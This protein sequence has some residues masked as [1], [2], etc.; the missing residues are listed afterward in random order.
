V[1]P[2][3]WN[4]QDSEGAHY[5]MNRHLHNAVL[6]FPQAPAGTKVASRRYHSAGDTYEQWFTSGG[7]FSAT[8]DN[9]RFESLAKVSAITIDVD[10]YE[11]DAPDAIIRWGAT[12]DERKS[13]MR[14][15][16]EEEVVQWMVDEDFVSCAIT[17]AASVGLPAAPNRILYTGQGLC[18]VYWLAAD[19]GGLNDV[20]T[21]KRMKE[22]IKRFVATDADKLWWWDK[23]AKDVGTRLIPIPGTRH[24]VTGKQV[25]LVR[26]H[27]NVTPLT[28][29]FEKLDAAYPEVKKSAKPRSAA[30]KAPG[31]P[32]ARGTGTWTIITFDPSKHTALEVGES[33][34]E[35]PLCQGSGYKRMSAEHYSCFSCETQFRVRPSFNFNI[36]FSEKEERPEGYLELTPEGH[37]LWPLSTPVRLLN[38]A[39]TGAGKTELMRRE[40]KAWAPHDDWNARV[41]AVAP[42]IALAG[43]LS[44]RLDMPHAD[45]QSALTLSQDSMACCFA[46]LA[47]KV[48]GAPLHV[49][50][51]TYV[52]V[53]EAESCLSQLY[54]M[55]KSGKDREALNVLIHAAAHAGKVM[56]A[57]ANAG[58]VCA[59]FMADVDAYATSKGNTPP[60]WK[61]WYTDAHRHDFEYVA[62]V[63]KPNK[64]GEQVVVA[65]SDAMHKGLILKELSE[66]LRL[67]IYIPGRE[68]AMGFAAVV[69]ERFPE[70]CVKV[71]V[72][73]V[74]NDNQHDF[75][76]EGLT[77]DVLIYNNAMATGVSYDVP[78]HYDRVHVLVGQGAVTDGTHI[79]QA[80]HRIRK[81]KS[82]VIAISGVIRPVV[83]DWRCTRDGHLIRAI[84]ALEAGTKTVQSIDTGLT[85][86]SDYMISEESKRLAIMQAT[87]LAG[88]FVR[89]FRWV[90]LWLE[91]HHNF[92][93][94]NGLMDK[95]F[96]QEVGDARELIEQEEALAIA[97][98]KPLSE[99]QVLRIEAHR[100]DTE[101]EYH[102][103]RAT[104]MAS[105]YGE[106]FENADE[107]EKARIAYE[108]KR[109]RL[110]QK[111]RV[112]AASCMLT[113]GG[114]DHAAVAAA[115]VRANREQTLM[116][117]RVTL[118]SAQ[119]FVAAL[120][121]LSSTSFDA[122]GRAPIT[123]PMALAACQTALPYMKHAGMRPREDWTQHP[124]RQLSTLFALAGLKLRSNRT[125]PK[126]DRTR[127]YYVISADFDRLNR[128]AAPMM[129][130]W[131]EGIEAPELNEK[132]EECSSEAA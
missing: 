90:L 18:L 4:A 99:A 58:P 59:Q 94:V 72:G 123:A 120:S 30:P 111:T 8:A 87:V 19:E 53:D 47:A 130:R 21:P 41:V 119:C 65:S 33:A 96:C 61:V 74:S 35:C 88:R 104:K 63:Y 22:T 66:G 108:D 117:T 43:N 125:G 23:S 124:M 25:L 10:A 81:P 20:W 2:E 40:R 9:M 112:Y 103:F 85:L 50:K 107:G 3:R 109:S 113:L 46:S 97:R 38:K 89:G 86:A 49:L 1:S 51:Q 114:K 76:Q 126:G 83:N 14:A 132:Q 56:L 26:G 121:A 129:Q 13:A 93:L 82:K 78:D 12:R 95:Q 122:Q 67:G 17:N 5:H 37:A 62:P 79:E 11:W 116:T 24:R 75:S 102:A 68:T 73:N 28:G 98:A 32:R 16:S 55:F 105:F 48:G 127:N 77:A 91:Q 34:A 60:E 92:S 6:L 39:R 101:A 36:D 29:W 71:V 69:R 110:A 52:M 45:A 100:A 64:K 15:A 7:F 131:R 106:A 118:P 115:E 128:L 31:A 54:G 42:T 84:N 80:V 27:D 70:K 44:R 57:D